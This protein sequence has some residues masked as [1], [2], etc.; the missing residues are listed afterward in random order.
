MTLADALDVA[1][2]AYDEDEAEREAILDE[3]LPALTSS[4]Q[5]LRTVVSVAWH[6]GAH[7]A[8][9]EAVTEYQAQRAEIDAE[10]GEVT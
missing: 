1:L 3:L 8:I 4:A 7:D 10:A 2:A 9:R 6:A 5:L